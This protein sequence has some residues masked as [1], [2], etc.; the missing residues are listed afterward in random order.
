MIGDAWAE[1]KELYESRIA[2]Q[3]VLHLNAHDMVPHATY[4]YLPYIEWLSWNLAQLTDDDGEER[5]WFVMGYDRTRG[6]WFPENP[7]VRGGGSADY[8]WRH[9]LN[10]PLYKFA[11]RAALDDN[12]RA[13]FGALAR[14]FL[15]H[16]DFRDCARDDAK[17]AGPFHR[18]ANHDTFNA[19]LNLESIVKHRGINQELHTK[20]AGMGPTMDVPEALRR[21]GSML[22]RSPYG[23]RVALI[24][25]RLELLTPNLHRS[26]RHEIIGDAEAGLAVETVAGWASNKDIRARRNILILLAHNIGDVA[27]ELLESRELVSIEVPLPDLA[28]R[29]TL[30]RHLATLPPHWEPAPEPRDED[31][32]HSDEY[33][34]MV[35]EW[36]PERPD[37]QFPTSLRYGEGVRQRDAAQLTAGLTLRGLYDAFLES[38][39]R[40]EPM[41]R[42]H[43]VDAKAREVERFSRGLL[44]LVSGDVFIESIGGLGHV[45]KYFEE[46]IP[47]LMA[48]DATSVG[49][50]L[51]LFGPPGT[52]KT[53]TLRALSRTTTL[54]VLRLKMPDELGIR[55]APPGESQDDDYANDLRL[56]L[57]YAR[58]IGP[59]FLC[60]D[61]VDRTFHRH[62]GAR[63]PGSRATGLLMDWL[64]RADSRGQVFFIGA[65]SRPHEI[66]PQMLETPLMDTLVYLL[67]TPTER[68]A[69]LRHAFRQLGAELADDVD[70]SGAMRHPAADSLNGEDL[71]TLAL[72]ALR[73]A[74]AAGADGVRRDDLLFCVNDFSAENSPATL[75][76]LSLNALRFASARS[77]LPEEILPPLSRTALDGARLAKDRIDARLRELRDQAPT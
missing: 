3:F 49:N 12:D 24:V 65:S 57:A 54:P 40:S 30:L 1:L 8:R 36:P 35:E 74:R 68:E 42:Q 61:R 10:T 25:D 6:A 4:G 26:R 16:S 34:K 52:G 72:R 27:P 20:S 53:L 58:S 19:L 13:V 9:G 23:R 45:R 39:P 22:H 63:A 66:E 77:Q 11:Q 37:M 51:W 15:Y 71:A 28:A 47:R 29:R 46:V 14:L 2:H 62:D 38:G 64:G 67:P 56:A 48:R 41:E 33:L 17:E 43:L 75:E 73:R 55:A 7:R 21:L 44:E 70:L 18:Y 76:W 5:E 59:T 69:V 60:L 31:E 50:G 32:A